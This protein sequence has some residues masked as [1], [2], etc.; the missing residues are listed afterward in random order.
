MIRIFKTGRHAH[1]TPLSYAA[2]WP[3]FEHDVRFVDRPEQADLHVFAHVLD[4]E[5]APREMI[6]DWRHRRVPV[7]LLSEEP[8]WDTIWG[9]HPL[10]PL[11][12][13]DTAFG[14][15]PVHQINHHTGRDIYRFAH[16]PY[17]LLTHHRFANTYAYRFA[18]NAAI[19]A[20]DW[21]AALKARSFDLA[22]MFE[23]RPEPYHAVC[24]AE[25]GIIG[26]CSWRTELAEACPDAGVLRLGQSWQG[27]RTRFELATDWHLDKMVRLDGRTR[28]MGALENTH[29]P[30]YITEKLF[31]AFACGA[32]PLYYAS[33]DHR[34]H[35]LGLPP[36]SWINLYG[37]SPQAAAER[38]ATLSACPV[39]PEAWHAAQAVLAQRFGDSGLWVE[40]RERFGAAVLDRLRAILDQ[41]I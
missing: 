3:L 35:D 26:L 31:D 20:A 36:E 32:V 21:E 4:I 30:D 41:A 24:W 19:S 29:Q 10:D 34:I 18:R 23:R 2:L 8:F 1:R 11:I 6:E 25:G 28:L 33:P 7:V 39:S 16:L 14:A 13:V 15:L 12:Y 9:G 5:H 40:E 17:Y 22:F 37:L 38:L 27:G